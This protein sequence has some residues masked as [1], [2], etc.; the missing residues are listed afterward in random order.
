MTPRERATMALGQLMQGLARAD[1]DTRPRTDVVNRRLGRL[2]RAPE[3][4]TSTR[5]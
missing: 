1:S 2:I 4:L 5:A 3:P